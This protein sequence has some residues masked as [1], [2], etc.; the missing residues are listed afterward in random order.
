MKLIKSE[1]LEAIDAL[2][3]KQAQLVDLFDVYDR[4]VGHVRRDPMGSYHIFIVPSLQTGTGNLDECRYLSAN[5]AVSSL[6]IRAGVIE[7]DEVL[8]GAALQQ[9]VDEGR[10]P[11]SV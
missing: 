4:F 7:G 6:L 1:W 10:V 5:A 11:R 9:A 3:T 2:D 8:V